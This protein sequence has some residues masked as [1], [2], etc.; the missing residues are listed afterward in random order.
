MYIF[1][2]AI[3]KVKS[4]ADFLVE[5]YTSNI[6]GINNQSVIEKQP[7]AE[8]VSLIDFIMDN[9]T[10][11]TETGE[12]VPMDEKGLKERDPRRHMVYGDVCA[13]YC[14]LNQI[15]KLFKVR[16]FTELIKTPS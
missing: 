5:N 2:K 6:Q 3:V 16:K 11:D 10:V 4:L 15:F 9:L 7:L 13:P 8:V 1:P 12:Y 14:L